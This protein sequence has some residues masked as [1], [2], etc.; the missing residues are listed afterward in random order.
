MDA[1]VTEFASVW[2]SKHVASTLFRRAMRPGLI[3][4]VRLGHCLLVRLCAMTVAR[5]QGPANK[6]IGAAKTVSLKA[7]KGTEIQTTHSQMLTGLDGH[8]VVIPQAVCD[9]CGHN[10]S[11]RVLFRPFS[12]QLSRS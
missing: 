2:Q 5:Q 3:I 9:R 11:T 4:N 10:M 7:S 8:G 12:V 6:Q 1:Y